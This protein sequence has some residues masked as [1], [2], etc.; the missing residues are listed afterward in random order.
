MSSFADVTTILRLPPLPQTVLAAKV[1]K[2][3]LSDLIRR[4]CPVCSCTDKVDVCL[5]PDNLI[6]S[7]CTQCHMVYLAMIPSKT[8]LMNFYATYS[9]YKEF[10]PP[11]PFRRV[12]AGMRSRTPNPHLDILLSTGGVQGQRICEMG[13]SYG[14][15]IEQCRRA[16][17]SVLGVEW[18]EHAIEY[19]ATRK[20]TVERE[21]PDQAIFDVVCAFQL[22]EHLEE[23]KNF[24][25]KASF[26][27]GK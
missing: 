17:A 23:P 18:D 2:W 20:I 5:R 9:S 22:I 16:G 10:F 11:S 26:F 19:L 7:K 4:T 21:L 14:N 1:P 27:V 15:F 13:C 24:I 25:S 3:D 8:Q 6:V 12:F